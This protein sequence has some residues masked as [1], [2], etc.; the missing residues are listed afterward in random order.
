MAPPQDKVLLDT[1]IFIDYLRTGLHEEWITGRVPGT[2][3]FLSS[4]VLLELRLGA[5]TPRRRRAVDRI[6]AAFPPS[7]WL[8]PGPELHDQA[9][10]LFRSVFGDAKALLASGDRLGAMNDLLIALTARHVGAR[11]VTGNAR[12]FE[13][14]A[15][16]LPGFQWSLPA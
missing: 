9:G 6:K 14:I 10:L 8:A 5:D 4:I 15:R 12:D 7:R 3:R 11:V 13:R 1:N 16:Q 2:V